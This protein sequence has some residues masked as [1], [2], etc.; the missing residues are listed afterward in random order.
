MRLDKDSE[1]KKKTKGWALPLIVLL[2]LIVGGFV[3]LI[4][5]N[6]FGTEGIKQFF[7]DVWQ[8]AWVKSAAGGLLIALIIF[9]VANE[10]KDK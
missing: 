3:F 7:R 4:S 6:P 10:K 1:L 5:T 9:A 8:M 2:L